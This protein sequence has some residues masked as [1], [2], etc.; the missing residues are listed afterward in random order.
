ME[1][2]LSDEERPCPCCGA[3]RTKIGEETSEHLEYEPP[4]MHVIEHVQIKYP[5]RK[6]EGQ[7]VT[8][9]KPR[10]AIE[11]WVSDWG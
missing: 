11:K 8:A 3:P 2:D 1:H 5:C 4:K 10:Q 9:L 6:C 7:L